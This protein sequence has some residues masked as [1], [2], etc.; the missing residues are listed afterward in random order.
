MIRVAHTPRCWWL[1]GYLVSQGSAPLD[2]PLTIINFPE[3]LGSCFVRGNFVDVHQHWKVNW[4]ALAAI[5]WIYGEVHRCMYLLHI[6][7]N[8]GPPELRIHNT[9]ITE[10]MFCVLVEVVISFGLGL[11]KL[12][13][14]LKGFG[15]PWC[16]CT[17]K[18][19]TSPSQF[20]SS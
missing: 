16:K 18:I 2:C 1:E 19:K 4:K 10:R 5:L 20:E 14:M 17:W 7:V 11:L 3:G 13:F 8:V 15:H 12:A 6:H 9:F